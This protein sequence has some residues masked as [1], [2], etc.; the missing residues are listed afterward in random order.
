M[1]QKVAH[2]SLSTLKIM[3]L[4]NDLRDFEFRRKDL[5]NL[6]T[7]FCILYY[8]RAFTSHGLCIFISQVSISYLGFFLPAI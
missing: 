2:I 5:K 7:D 8:C 1:H 6:V 4:L 3:W